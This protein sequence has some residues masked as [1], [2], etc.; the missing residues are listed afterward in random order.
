[1]KFTKRDFYEL[2]GIVVINIFM[3]IFEIEIVERFI[4]MLLVLIYWKL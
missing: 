3:A 2:T 4:I 1:M